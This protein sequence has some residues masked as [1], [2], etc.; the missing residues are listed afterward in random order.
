M[1]RLVNTAGKKLKMSGAQIDFVITA[2]VD[3]IL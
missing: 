2:F 3:S 1:K